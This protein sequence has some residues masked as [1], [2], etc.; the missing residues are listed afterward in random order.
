MACLASDVRLAEALNTSFA[1]TLLYVGVLY[2][3]FN[4]G[5]RNDRHIIIYRLTT[6]AV[7]CLFLEAYIRYRIPSIAQKHS[8]GTRAPALAV[9]TTLTLLLYTGHLL[10]TPRQHLSTHSFADVD[11][12]YLAFRNYVFAPLLEE[13]V[14]RRQ[15]LVIWSCQ[16]DEWRLLFP[17]AMFA[18]AHVHHI[19]SLGLVGLL[20]QIAYTFLFGIYAAALY[21]NTNTVWAPFAAHVVCNVLELPDVVAISTHPRRRMVC[22][23]YAVSIIGFALGFEPL[24]T[25]VRPY[26]MASE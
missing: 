8:G 1:I 25:L 9:G 15:T 3:P 5:P 21:V 12:R 19:R 18:L 20:F 23:V 13:I 7:L 17:A 14:F 26:Q 11:H 10:V 2:L 4:A 22:V 16:R 6:L 24:T